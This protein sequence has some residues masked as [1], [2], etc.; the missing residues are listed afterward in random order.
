MSKTNRISIVVAAS[1]GAAAWVHVAAAQSGAPAGHSLTD[2]PYKNG[3]PPVSGGYTD[4][5]QGGTKTSGDMP[6]A[7]PS[8]TGKS[9]TSGQQPQQQKD[10]PAQAPA[11]GGKTASGGSSG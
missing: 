11:Q 8:Q 2:S 10:Q 6:V 3:P 1:F 5:S 7:P 4:T 9:A